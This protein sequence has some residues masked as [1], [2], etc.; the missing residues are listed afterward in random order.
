MATNNFVL[1]TEFQGVDFS[2]LIT[3][4]RVFDIR[5]IVLDYQSDASVLTRWI[6]KRSADQKTMYLNINQ[7]HFGW[8]KNFELLTKDFLCQTCGASFSRLHR[9]RIHRCL[10]DEDERRTFPGGN[11]QP[12]QT[13]FERVNEKFGTNIEKRLYP[14]RIVYDVEC[15][16]RR[17]RLFA[18]SAKVDIVNRHELLSVSVCSNVPGYENAKCLVREMDPQQ[19]TDRFVDYITEIAETAGALMLLRHSRLIDFLEKRCEELA[20]VEE[21]YK[22]KRLSPP[23]FDRAYKAELSLMS[24]KKWCT[25]VPVIGFN[26]QKYDMNIFKTSLMKTLS[27]SSEINY[28]VKRNNAFSCVE[29]EVFKF[30]DICNY[31]SPGVSYEKYVAAY[32]CK[33]RKGFFPY[34]WMTD[35]E[36]L[37]YPRLPDKEHFYSSLKNS[38]ISDDDYEY[39][40]TV[41]NELGMKTFEDFLVWYNNLDVE[42]ML[43]AIHRQSDVYWKMEIDMFK[44]AMS[45]PGLAVFWLFAISRTSIK[46][47]IRLLEDRDRELYPLIKGGLVGGP[48]I[49]FHRYHEKNVT[50]I[51]EIYYKDSAKMCER[52]LGVDANA[53]YLWC[54]MQTLPCGRPRVTRFSDEGAPTISPDVG[55]KVAQGWLAWMESKTRQRIF[56]ELNGK[57]IRVGDHGI[58]VDGFCSEFN[59][60]YQFHGCYWHGH[61]CTKSLAAQQIHPH[62]RV[63]VKDIYN[64]TLEKER[65]IRDLG[66]TLVRTWECEWEATVNKNPAIKGF[67][68]RFFSKTYPIPSKKDAKSRVDDIREGKFFGLVECDIEVPSELRSFYAEMPPIFKNTLVSRKDLGAYGLNLANRDNRLRQP[69]RMLIGSMKGTRILLFSELARWYLQNGLNITRLHTLI[70]YTPEQPFKLFGDSVSDARREGDADASKAIL[71]DTN[72]L[73]GNSC[74]G[75]TIVNKDRHKDVKYVHG[76]KD[77]YF[78][79]SRR[80]FDSLEEISDEFYEVSFKKM[81]V[82]FFKFLHRE[83]A[84]S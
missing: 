73:I 8:I 51:R 69:Q 76:H 70:E 11:W 44:D 81:R 40:K 16:L 74:Y 64:G 61:T 25:T 59:T 21:R 26:S 20:K 47:P 36:K 42:P 79:I 66:Y 43:E 56:H 30:L 65:Y 82:R 22:D 46:T 14:Y 28:V 67:L 33:A 24:F 5:I 38:S 48:S 3:M 39:C 78:A 4:E 15:L 31:L 19:L 12:P 37:K 62:K 18:S 49:V 53:L 13:V 34:E 71:A 41:W 29:T 23:S 75:K 10:Q 58:P 72:K 60:V 6:S 32:G 17:E 63:P 52:I 55:S 68:S 35:M 84:H 83:C 45:L 7:H 77:A 80:N 50:R 27:S 2:D 57:E 54:I 1:P 9:K